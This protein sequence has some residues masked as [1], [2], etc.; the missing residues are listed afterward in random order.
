MD[1]LSWRDGGRRLSTTP[2]AFFFTFL[3]KPLISSDMRES[4]RCAPPSEP[5]RQ[6]VH[7]VCVCLTRLKSVRRQ[8]A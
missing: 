8:H 7:V 2:L 3:R 6:G 5:G 4:D 1:D